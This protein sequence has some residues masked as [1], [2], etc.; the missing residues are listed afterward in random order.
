VITERAA[1]DDAYSLFGDLISE[2]EVRAGSG[3]TTQFSHYDVQLAGR[4]VDSTDIIAKLAQWRAEDNRDKRG[5]GRPPL[6]SDRTVLVICL[7][8]VA[9]GSPEMRNVLWYRLTDQARIALGLADIHDSGDDTKDASDW[10]NRIWRRLHQILEPLDG[11][12]A[13]RRLLLLKEREEIMTLRDRNNTRIK[14]ERLD[15]FTNAMLEMTFQALPREYRRNWKGACSV[16]Q[17]AV[18]APSQQRRWR[19]DKKTKKEVPS[20]NKSTR[21]EINRWV[22]ELDADLYPVEKGT[23]VKDHSLATAPGEKDAKKWISPIRWELSYMANLVI[24]VG[25]KPGVN[26]GHPQL[27]I[28][29]SLGTPN[30]DVGQMTVS[31]MQSIQDRGHHVSRLTADRGYNGNTKPEDFVVPMK[32]MGIPLVVDYN[33]NQKGRNG[34]VG[35]TIQVEGAHYCPATP[36]TLLDATIDYDDQAIDFDEYVAKIDERALYRTKRKEKPDERGHYPMVCPAIGPSATVECPF[37]AKH[38]HASKKTKRASVIEENLPSA[39]NK[40]RICAQS[41][42]DFAPEDGIEHEQL[43]HYGSKEW[44]TTYQHDRNSME[45]MNNYIKEGPERL[46]DPRS[47][48]V[49]GLAAQQFIMT[50]LLVSANLRKIA[51]FLRDTRRAEPKKKYARGRDTKKMSAYV[52]WRE[53]VER[54]E[55]LPQLPAS[56]SSIDPPTR[57]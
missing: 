6:L 29:A 26:P 12:R 14:R 47:R 8:L 42:V 46:H 33:K 28:A 5:G 35:G 4:R 2:S 39:A 20:F 3:K 36:D 49:R 21:E 44:R 38:A 31:L 19:R 23:P 9:E 56:D 27:I 32:A 17:T 50:M 10:Y 43:L 25:D 7:L 48:R 15:Y 34:G 22:M 13:P 1:F 53:K 41:S 40:P 52:R 54:V 16:D 24:Q 37:R 18:R 57:T 55:K 11:W 30:K 51:R 45:S